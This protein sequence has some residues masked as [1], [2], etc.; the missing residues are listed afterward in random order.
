MMNRY[1][2]TLLAVLSAQAVLAQG[3]NTASVAVDTSGER[4]H[5]ARE[6][7]AVNAKHEQE[8]AQCKGKFAANDCLKAAQKSKR[9]SLDVLRRQEIALNDQE[10]KAKAA[11]QMDKVKKRSEQ[12]KAVVPE[13]AA[14]SPALSIST[15]QNNKD[16]EQEQARYDEKLR[17]AQEHRAK[18]EQANREKKKAAA[19]LP[20]PK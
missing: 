20:T 3:V 15:R 13:V 17:A 16:T 12:K 2:F 9:K 5:I 4:Q 18:V 19:D 10:R 6:R 1:T 11:A 8:A 14:S 7:D